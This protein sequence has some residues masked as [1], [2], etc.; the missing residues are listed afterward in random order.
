MKQAVQ[1]TNFHDKIK[2]IQ[3]AFSSITLPVNHRIPGLTS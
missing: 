1:V 3:P 2:Y